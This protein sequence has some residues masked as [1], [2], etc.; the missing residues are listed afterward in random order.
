MCEPY[1]KVDAITH[2]LSIA[3]PSDTH[4]INLA[5]CQLSLLPERLDWMYHHRLIPK[6]ETKHLLYEPIKKV[7]DTIVSHAMT[8]ITEPTDKR[9]YVPLLLRELVKKGS[10]F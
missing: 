3:T 5:A 10:L 8:L 7:F 4:L 6:L 2:C 9:S 1:A